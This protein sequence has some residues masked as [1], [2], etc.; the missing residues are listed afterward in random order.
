MPSPQ[1]GNNA[2]LSKSFAIFLARFFPAVATFFVIWGYSHSLSMQA[3]GQ[4]STFWVQLNVLSAFICLG[5]HS[6][7]LTFPPSYIQVQIHKIPRQQAMWLAVW[8]IVV[9]GVFAGLQFAHLG[10][11]A[12]LA[13]LF[14]IAFSITTITDALLMVAGRFR[15]LVVAN[16]LY[17][18]AY[19]GLHWFAL[20]NA[21]P[22]HILLM[23]LCL[24]V[25]TKLSI[26]IYVAYRYFRQPI[27]APQLENFEIE[28]SRSLWLHLAFYDVVQLLSMWIDKFIIAIILSPERSAVYYNGTL[29][30]PFLPIL[31]SAASSAAL[32]QLAKRPANDN[33][34]IVS[35]MNT[36]GKWLASIVFPVFGFLFIFSGDVVTMLF[37]A[38]YAAAIPV[39]M[40]SVCILPV[41][42]YSFTTVLQKLQK[43]KIINLGATAE[44]LVAL[45][46]VYPFYSWLGLPGVA[47]S[48]VVS[49]Y[50]QA[51]FYLYQS[52]RL[53]QTTVNAL[54]PIANWLWKMGITIV[55]FLLLR[56]F[57]HNYFEQK[58][59]LILA[60]CQLGV[61][62]AFY[63]WYDLKKQRKHGHVQ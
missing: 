42:A 34:A 36:S 52:A 58:I 50:L 32:M 53:L 59:V 25:L 31:L 37:S 7:V 47:L 30:I 12:W 35:L 2:F 18:L 22:F 49:T 6:L 9:G 4:Y 16:V 26:S 45:A 15:F 13:P 20:V 40:V 11:A 54:L 28:K 60:I 63:V 43:G 48:F 8:A 3:Y 33:T 17:G 10:S 46:L 61:L 27:P 29:N 51:T 38:K 21:Q 57:T 23:L 41:R 24:S 44:L 55:T 39:F 1:A 62:I 19:A 5:I 56:Y 14:L